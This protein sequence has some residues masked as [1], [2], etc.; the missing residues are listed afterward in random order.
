M[1]YVPQKN[2]NKKRLVLVILTIIMC[3]GI[4]YSAIYFV[5]FKQDSRV[6]KIETGLISIDYQE[7]SGQ[8]EIDTVPVIDEV[9]LTNDP[10]S[11][12]VKN[13]S[14][15]PINLRIELLLDETNTIN[16]KAVKYAL[17]K[18]DELVKKDNLSNLENNTIYLYEN[19][20][21]NEV[22]SY[23]LHIWVDY[24][25]ENPNE[26]FKGQI[27]VTGE[28]FDIIFGASESGAEEIINKAVT[29]ETASAS[30]FSG[31]LVAINTEG[32]LYNESDTN[33]E[34]REYRYSGPS[35]NNYI[36]FND[37]GDSTTE[38]NELWR[39][40]GIFKNSSGQWNLKLMRDTLL[41]DTE[42]PDTYTINGVGYDFNSY[43]AE[44]PKKTVWSKPDSETYD[45]DWTNAG[46]QY[47]LNTPQDSSGIQGYYSNA[48]FSS[49]AKS[50]ID[51]NYEYTL[52]AVNSAG[53]V[54]NTYLDERNEN[55]VL[56]GNNFTWNGAVSLLYPSDY[57][58]SA[59][60]NYWTETTMDSYATAVETSWIHLTANQNDYEWTMTPPLSE[61]ESY[62]IFKLGDN[63]LIDDLL[64]YGYG[65]R[66]VLNLLSSADVDMNHVGSKT[67]PYVVI[68]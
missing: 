56:E 27:K 41:S 23:K 58:Y 16:Y 18:D 35:V 44:V 7:G 37:D 60:S 12:T 50:L 45:D 28:S 36:I 61:Y 48:I 17:Y 3:L 24:Y 62:Y 66:P 39:I 21:A 30:D 32:T 6:N 15:I 1:N 65:V 33:Q 40:V 34:I 59:S 47:F 22:N 55:N 38:A 43:E 2:G 57:G 10:Y 46:V 51:Q 9:G 64:F 26:T 13:T 54:V 29:Y 52:G 19:M 5:Y 31:G 42:I 8:I 4:S 14:I 20:H 11:F 67:D 49:K 25:Y 63:I 53:N 68:E